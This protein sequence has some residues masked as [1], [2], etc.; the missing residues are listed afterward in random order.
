VAE[1]FIDAALADR[2]DLNEVLLGV[3]KNDT[4]AFAN[5]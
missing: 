1:R 3:E 2:A 4:Q 5:L